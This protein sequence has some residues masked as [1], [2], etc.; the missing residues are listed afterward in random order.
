MF[1]D[2]A[3]AVTSPLSFLRSGYSPSM[4]SVSHI[5]PMIS[6]AAFH[7]NRRSGLMGGG[8]GISVTVPVSTSVCRGGLMRYGAASPTS[9][10]VADFLV[11]SERHGSWRTVTMK[12]LPSNWLRCVALPAQFI[13]VNRPYRLALA[14]S[15]P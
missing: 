8:T 15:G 9:R 4:N 12:P 14:L 2:L 13:R 3:A 10:M 7:T 6:G 1:F 11:G 5:L